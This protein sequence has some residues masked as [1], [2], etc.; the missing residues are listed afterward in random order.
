MKAVDLRR[1]AQHLSY[2]DALIAATAAHHDTVLI[3]RDPH[4]V[5]IPGMLL[6]QEQLPAK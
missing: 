3:H 6:A 4:F 1:A 5:T 2:V